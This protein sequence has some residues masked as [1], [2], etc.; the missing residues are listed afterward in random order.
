MHRSHSSSR[1]SSFYHACLVKRILASNQYN[2]IS[3]FVRQIHACCREIIVDERVWDFIWW[4]KENKELAKWNFYE[5]GFQLSRETLI[6]MHG[7]PI[8][9]SKILPCQFI[10]RRLGI[11]GIVLFLRDFLDQAATTC[12]N[13]LHRFNW[14]DCSCCMLS[15]CTYATSV[16]YF[17][18]M[19]PIR[20]VVSNRKFWTAD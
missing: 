1:V 4:N 18:L 10:S 3:I 20:N 6:L 12:F 9:A 19:E 8:Q 17:Q 5:N 11:I 13:T 14:N 15:I 16:F 7:H 2:F